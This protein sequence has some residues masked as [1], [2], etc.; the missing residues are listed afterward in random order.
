MDRFLEKSDL[1]I[2]FSACLLKAFN[3]SSNFKGLMLSQPTRK[4][5]NVPNAISKLT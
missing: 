3:L 4:G 1:R 2:G 5:G